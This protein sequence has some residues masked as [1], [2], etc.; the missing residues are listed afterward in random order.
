MVLY[1]KQIHNSLWS[2]RTLKDVIN[3]VLVLKWT[4]SSINFTVYVQYLPVTIWTWL[5]SRGW[6]YKW[7]KSVAGGDEKNECICILNS[8]WQFLT[9]DG[10]FRWIMFGFI[11]I[12]YTLFENI[13]KYPNL[14]NYF[15]LYL[16]MSINIPHPIIVY[17]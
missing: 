6:K 13:G 10:Y 16:E 17:R 1:C 11:F 15:F 9:K 4:W 3:I 5:V 7:K 14:S 12:S 8:V 2:I